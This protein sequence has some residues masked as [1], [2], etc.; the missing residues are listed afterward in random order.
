MPQNKKDDQPKFWKTV[1]QDFKNGDFKRTMRQDYDDLKEF[2]L[3]DQQKERLE[4]MGWFRKWFYS[5]LWLLKIL[6]LKLSSSRRIILLIGFVLLFTSMNNND[7]DKGLFIIGSILILFVLMLELK[8]KLLAYH[9][10]LEGRLI[11]RSLMPE[12]NPEVPGWDVWLFTRSANDVGG[13][14]VDYIEI[15]R[16][17][18]GLTLADVSGKGLGAALLTA[19]LQATIQAIVPDYKSLDQLLA[20]INR[21]FYRDTMRKSFASL[22]FLEI[23]ELS[24]KIHFV[25]SGHLPPVKLVDN[26]VVE[27]SKGGPALGLSP[28]SVY[29]EQ[30]TTLKKDDFLLIYS[31]GLTE[32][33]NRKGDFFGERRLFDLL[34]R[35]KPASAEEM[36]ERMVQEVDLFIEG[37][38]SY[39][40][41]S[42]IILKF[43][44]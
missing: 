27:L 32:S 36:G 25:N 10:L 14:L 6:F 31:D 4:S 40:D 9:E 43:R 26:Q 42:I 1:R 11:Q 8:D 13:D 22:V 34:S 30:Q 23:E 7:N 38:R 17:R 21:I 16:G 18:I 5:I 35:I 29:T 39:D 41:L 2:Y 33:R 28:D 19:K 20:K 37:G 12:E 44:G 3:N 15:E 24:G